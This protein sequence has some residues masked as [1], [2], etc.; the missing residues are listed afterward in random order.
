MDK[1]KGKKKGPRKSK[2]PVKNPAKGEVPAQKIPDSQLPELLRMFDEAYCGASQEDWK[3]IK[4]GAVEIAISEESTVKE[5]MDAT[6]ALVEMRKI[7]LTAAKIFVDAI[8][9]GNSNQEP[10]SVPQIAARDLAITLSD[11]SGEIAEAEAREADILRP[12]VGATVE[13]TGNGEQQTGPLANG[14]AEE[15]GEDELANLRFQGFG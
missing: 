13:I 3:K 1:R 7:G 11:L 6:F 15:T 8:Q 14:S 10:K 2:E 9:N 5:K 12:I 4:D